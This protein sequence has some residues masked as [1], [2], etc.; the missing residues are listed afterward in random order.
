MLKRH[1]CGRMPLKAEVNLQR[2]L[3]R[4]EKMAATGVT[5]E[6]ELQ[7]LETVGN[8]VHAILIMPSRGLYSVC[9]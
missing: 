5:D 2:L 7:R 1:L 4:C 8:V 9:L 6:N 3:V